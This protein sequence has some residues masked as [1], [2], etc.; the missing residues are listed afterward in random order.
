[1]NEVSLNKGVYMKRMLMISIIIL[2]LVGACGESEKI[3]DLEERIKILES[4]EDI[5]MMEMMSTEND[6]TKAMMEMMEQKM[7]DRNEQ[8]I[9]VL[10]ERVKTLEEINKELMDALPPTF[11]SISRDINSLSKRI[12]QLEK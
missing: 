7:G 6:E 12:D 4:E 8:S 11:E 5:S 9:I 10:Q 1:M 2:T 3:T